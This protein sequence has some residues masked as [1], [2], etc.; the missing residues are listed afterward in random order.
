M[1]RNLEVFG[2][3]CFEQFTLR[4]LTRI[5]LLVGENNAGKTTI[6]EAILALI[7][8]GDPLALDTFMSRRGETLHVGTDGFVTSL[9]ELD[10]RRLFHGHSIEPGTSL[11]IQSFGDDEQRL[12]RL[13]IATN[14]ATTTTTPPPG[15]AVLNDSVWFVLDSEKDSRN[16]LHREMRL[17]SH[18]GI[19]PFTV[20]F[21][22]S[23]R[24]GIEPLSFV[25][26]DAPLRRDTAEAWGEVALT[27]GERLVEECL[28]LVVPKLERVA[29]LKDRTTEHG[30]FRVKLQGE[31]TPV[32]IGSMGGGTSRL[33]AL[34][35]ALVQC[36]NGFLLIDEIDTGIHHSIL[37][38][39]WKFVLRVSEKLDVQVFATTHSLDCVRG[40]AQVCHEAGS[41]SDDRISM[42][43]I[44]SNRTESVH[45]NEAQIIIA[46]AEGIETR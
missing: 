34:A 2:F 10:V 4:D 33:L 17:S 5:N 20:G 31:K 1:I 14:P 26:V 13:R 27:E 9:Y 43:R 23:L 30:V 39:V 19:E 25:S 37:N 45:Y 7:R 38:D 18:G 8:R 16:E 11:A 36:R 29:Y 12:L 15:V 6:L 42:H 28:R 3:R 22:E 44:E 21:S 32:P 46:A 24:E 40:L 35:I 41:D